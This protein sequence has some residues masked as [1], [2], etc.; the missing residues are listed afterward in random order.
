MSKRHVGLFDCNGSVRWRTIDNLNLILL[1]AS[2]LWIHSISFSLL[3]QLFWSFRRSKYDIL[4]EHV[5]NF[6]QRSPGQVTSI[7]T[8]KAQLVIL[9]IDVWY[10]VFLCIVWVTFSML[11]SS[12]LQNVS[13]NTLKRVIQYMRAAKFV[14]AHHYPLEDLDPSIGPCVYKKGNLN[15]NLK[16]S[17]TS[18]EIVQQ[19]FYILI[20]ITFQ[21]IKSLCAV[22]DFWSLI[23]RRA[24]PKMTSMRITTTKM[25]ITRRQGGLFLQRGESW[26]RTCCHKRIILVSRNPHSKHICGVWAEYVEAFFCVFIIS[27]KKQVFK[28]LFSC[29]LCLFSSVILRFKGNSPVWP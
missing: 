12:F 15:S 20:W 14:E 13:D 7:I 10:S 3:S 18:F 23:Q 6:L 21:G 17:K 24:S 5:S 27:R 2:F 19:S 25:K 28:M 29:I 11:S 16:G 4:M 9:F 8:L 1:S 26:S 22:W